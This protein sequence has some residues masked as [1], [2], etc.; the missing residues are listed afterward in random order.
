MKT[1]EDNREYSERKSFN[2]GDQP[3]GRSAEVTF[4]DGEVLQ[5]SVL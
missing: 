1:F 2:E 5:G 4:K 3:Q